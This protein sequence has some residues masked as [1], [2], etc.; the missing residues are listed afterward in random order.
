VAKTVTEVTRVVAA[1]FD[2]FASPRRFLV[3]P[4]CSVSWPDVVRFYLGMLLVSF[5]IAI[6]FAMQGA[7]LI[8]PFAGLEM[9]V[10]GI[11]LYVVARRATDWQEISISGDRIT[12]IERD[13][14]RE[15]VYSYQRA[16]VQIVHERAAINGHPSRLS[17]RSHGCSTE[18]GRCLNEEE[19]RYLAD[20]LIRAVRS[21]D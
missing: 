14:G 10:L 19:K 11:A 9:S 6:A 18:I 2:Q 3:R 15:R 21:R 5:T 4:N 12:I 13:S 20:Q 8:L 7:W 1:Q 17:I 16:W